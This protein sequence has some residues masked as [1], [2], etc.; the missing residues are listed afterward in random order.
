MFATYKEIQLGFFPTSVKYFNQ[1]IHT[2]IKSIAKRK[3]LIRHFS[4]FPPN[5]FV[6]NYNVERAVISFRSCGHRR[7]EIK[8]CSLLCTY[9]SDSAPN[10]S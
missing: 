6:L 5:A 8:A 1:I 4:D 9:F 7:T 3:K 10:A 2:Q